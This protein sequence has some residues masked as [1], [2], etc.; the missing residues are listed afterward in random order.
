MLDPNDETDEFDEGYD[1]L[2]EPPPGPTPNQL[3]KQAAERGD[4]AFFLDIFRTKPWSMFSVAEMLKYL[5]RACEVAAR[6]DPEGYARETFARMVGFNSFVLLRSQLYVADRV[7][8][9][10]PHHTTPGMAD[11]SVEVVERLLPR[12]A[13]VQKGTAELLVGQAQAARL[14]GLARAKEARAGRAVAPDP[15]G[16]EAAGEKPERLEPDAMDADGDGPRADVVPLPVRGR[17]RG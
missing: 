1:D 10:G 8:G 17:R 2:Y 11:L 7:V 6:A 9:R 15:P 13:E 3:R 5:M 4:V 14:W 12:L 16:V